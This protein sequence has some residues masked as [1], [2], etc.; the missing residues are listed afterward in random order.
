[1]RWDSSWHAPVLILVLVA[2]ALPQAAA[3]ADLRSP[4]NFSEAMARSQALTQL[5]HDLFFEKSLSSSGKLS[6]ASCHDQDH[7]FTPAN[8][9]AVQMG[10]EKLDQ[11]GTRAVPTLKYLQASRPFEQ[12]HLGTEDDGGKENADQGPAGGL[13]WDGRVDRP[14]DQARIPILSPIEMANRD[15][16]SV[17]AHILAAGYGPRLKTLFGEAALKDSK[18]AFAALT[19]AIEA[20]EQ[21]R[22]AFF[23]FTSKFDYWLEGQAELTDA[24][25]RGYAAFIDPE[26][27]N[28]DSC[29]K[30]ALFPN[31][32]HPDLTDFGLIATAVPRNSEILANRDPHYFDLG[33]CGPVRTDLSD[34]PELCGIFKTPT[35]RNVALKK[36]FFHNGV[37]KTLRDA[38]RF[39]AERDVYPER[40]YPKNPD[41]S[42]AIYNDIPPE[43]RDNINHDPPFDRMPGEQPRLKDSE[44]DDIVAF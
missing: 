39:Y 14:R 32:G 29:H 25:K 27:G 15:E 12:H 28:C 7:A 3:L 17:M 33:A 37:V 24:E 8:D 23:P 4:R 5:G 9:L 6:C 43:F 40:W 10:G 35:L 2:A 13:T 19:E 31:G 1:M 26:R 34:R 41:G 44:I 36:R 42:V 30:A 21:K 38:V 11:F 22:E 18:A 16:D 20:F